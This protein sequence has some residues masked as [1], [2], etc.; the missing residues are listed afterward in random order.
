[1]FLRKSTTTLRRVP[2]FLA[3]LA[4]AFVLMACGGTPVGD[5]DHFHG[6]AA[7]NT[8]AASALSTD[9]FGNFNP[10][11][12]NSQAWYECNCGRNPSAPEQSTPWT[13]NM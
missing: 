1:L 11:V 8:R 9:S 12:W 6:G 4:S 5:D 13:P 10:A 3:V 7:L 2:A